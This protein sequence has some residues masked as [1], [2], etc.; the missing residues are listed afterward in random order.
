MVLFKGSMYKTVRK[1]V[2][3]FLYDNYLIFFNVVY[4][5]IT[6]SRHTATSQHA[7]SDGKWKIKSRNFHLILG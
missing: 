6:I 5:K 3:I 1:E 2:K 7:N 4:H